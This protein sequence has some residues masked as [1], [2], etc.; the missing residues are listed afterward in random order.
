MLNVE[1]LQHEHKIHYQNIISNF[2]TLVP[3]TKQAFSSLDSHISSKN[4]F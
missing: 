3:D 1:L 2:H 4:L